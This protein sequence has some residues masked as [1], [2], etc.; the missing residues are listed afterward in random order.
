VHFYSAMLMMRILGK[1]GFEAAY[2]D[3]N[4]GFASADVIK[5][6]QLFRGFRGLKPFQSGYLANRFQKWEGGIGAH[7][8]DDARFASIR[9]KYS[10]SANSHSVPELLQFLTAL[11]LF[12]THR[13]D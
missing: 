2:Q 12:F 10:F 4:G 8:A 7:P 3:K 5:A 13:A 11:M 1:E 9:Y 6:F